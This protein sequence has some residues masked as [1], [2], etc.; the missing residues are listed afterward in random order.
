V[1][2]DCLHVRRCRVRLARWCERAEFY[3]AKRGWLPVDASEA[4]KKGLKEAYFGSLPNDRVE[5]SAGRD[6]V[7]DPAQAGEP[8]NYFVYP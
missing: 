7:L 4:K 2:D 5:F 3:D 8:L 1:V 6:I